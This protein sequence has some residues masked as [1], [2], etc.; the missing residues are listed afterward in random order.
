MHD[1]TVRVGRQGLD[2][3]QGHAVP[4]LGLL[5]RVFWPPIV[6]VAGGA[7]RKQM[8][9]WEIIIRTRLMCVYEFLIIGN[10]TYWR[11]KNNKRSTGDQIKQRVH[12][13]KLGR[14]Y[15]VSLQR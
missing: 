5:A 3:S 8:S 12:F 11:K 2:T 13:I 7:L 10:S 6:V 1:P 9:V 4:G 15:V 14:L